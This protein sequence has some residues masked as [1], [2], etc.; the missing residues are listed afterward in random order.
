MVVKVVMFMSVKMGVKMVVKK[1]CMRGR[2]CSTLYPPNYPCVHMLS[3][4]VIFFLVVKVIL[5]LI[6]KL[7][8]FML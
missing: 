5:F 1:G 4:K 8:K 6:V 3:V 7:V 2:S